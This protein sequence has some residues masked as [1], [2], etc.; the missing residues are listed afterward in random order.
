MKK[1][2]SIFL[3]S[4]KPERYH[5]V[6]ESMLPELLYYFDG[7]NVRSFSGLVNSCV[8]ASNTEIVILV[9]DKARPKQEHIKKIVD[10]LN[11]GYGLVALHRFACFGFKKELL[12]K[13]G[14]FDERYVGGCNEDHDFIIRVIMANVAMYV[15]EE[16]E[17]NRGPCSWKDDVSIIHWNNKWDRWVD[18]KPNYFVR[19]KMTEE[20][21]NYNLGPSIPTKFLTCREHTYITCPFISTFAIA[22]ITSTVSVGFVN[23]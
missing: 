7:S 2:Y 19:K 15:T 20:T 23:N 18:S 10:L 14:M 21:Y 16:V 22:Q 12:R 9:G 3:I 1:D 11:K 17:Y 13:I 4:N 8:E 5:L 6:Q